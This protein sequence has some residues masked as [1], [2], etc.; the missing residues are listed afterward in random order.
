M[1]RLMLIFLFILSLFKISSTFA[2]TDSITPVKSPQKKPLLCEVK[3]HDGSLY[4]GYIESQNDSTFFVK[5]SAGVVI[6]IPKSNVYSVEFISGHSTKDSIGNLTIHLPAIANQYYVASSNAFLLKKGE[7]YGSSSYFIFYNVN[8]AFNQH[9][10]LGV[11]TS[12]LAA[13]IMLRAKLNFELTHKLYLG[14]EGLG[15]SG[16]WL[17]PKS[18]GGGGLA[19]LTYG[20]VKKN[21]TVSGGYGNVDYYIKPHKKKGGY[22]NPGHYK[23]YNSVLIGAAFSYTISHKLN[24]VAEAFAAPQLGVYS[25]SPAI[26]TTGSQN[27]SWIF[28]LEGFLNTTNAVSLPVIAVPYL[29]FSFRL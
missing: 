15:G 27:I 13:P 17:N 26:R 24:F 8:Y 12:F 7:V 6:H 19:K 2:Q 21:F 29:G 22:S 5:S 3:M 20:N 10:S 14:I 11:S 28:G 23:N 16:S 1:Q 25:L 4:K 9:F 18:Y